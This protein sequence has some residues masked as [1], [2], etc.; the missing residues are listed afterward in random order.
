MK[1]VIMAAGANKNWNDYL[2]IPKHM[3]KIGTEPLIGRTTR[4]LKENGI[5]D[6]IITCNNN[7][8]SQFGQTFEPTRYDCEI[9]R[10]EETFLQEPV[11]FLYGDVCYSYE[12]MKTI[13]NTETDDILWFG[14]EGEMFAIKIQ[15]CEH[16]KQAKAHIKDLYLKGEINRCICWEIYRYLHNINLTEHIITDDY[17]K[18]LDGTDDIDFPW[19]YENF[20]ER[21]KPLQEKISIIIPYYKTYSLTKTIIEEL[22][23]QRKW[24]NTELILVDDSGDGEG[25]AKMV[26]IYIKNPENRGGPGSR[27][28]G[29][30]AA[31]G[32]YIVFVDCDDKILENYVFTIVEEA[33]KH[34]DL[35]WLSWNCPYGKAIVKSTKQINIAPWGCL[36]KK[37]I[38]DNIRFNDKLNL[39]EERE[40]WDEVFKIPD[41]KIGFSE[42]IIYYYNIREDSLVRRHSRGEISAERGK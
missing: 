40:F 8:Y 3:V 5:N 23:R 36:F 17:I 26:D 10:F 22:N 1:Y 11:C 12:A 25:F 42:N 13:V 19:D 14:S 38:F 2:G 34:N 29:L 28:I 21:M 33:K 30:N 41:L 16:F 9:D 32:D 39:G 6:Y 4:L 24:T 35:T 15:N 37:R 31:T 20:L 18:I 7:C 27:N